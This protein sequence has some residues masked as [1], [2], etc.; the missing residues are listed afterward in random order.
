[1]PTMTPT[2]WFDMNAE[3]AIAFWCSII[4]DS[5]IDNIVRAP[6]DTPSNIECDAMVVSFTLQG[7][8]WTGINGGPQFPFSE[9]I[10]FTLTCED[11]AEVDAIWDKLTDGGS[12]SMCGWCKDRYGFSWQ[13]VPKRLYEL[14]ADPD[15]DRARRASQEMLTQHGKLDLALIEAAADG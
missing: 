3:E 1:M 13:V 5:H 2:L 15:R 10:S 8:S 4:P 14:L 12:E 9:V 7:Q 6:S 11:Q